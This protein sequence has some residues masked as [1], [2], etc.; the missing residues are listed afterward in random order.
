MT[1]FTIIILGALVVV[2]LAVTL[3][4][5]PEAA[6][7]GALVLGV[8]ILLAQFLI[9]RL[10]AILEYG[11][12][13]GT[14]A[15]EAAATQTP[16]AET[17]TPAETAPPTP[18]PHDQGQAPG[19]SIDW[20][21]VLLVTGVIAAAVIV[22]LLTAWT[23]TSVARARR[24]RRA[25]LA[26]WTSAS[27]AHDAVIAG[28]AKHVF[29]PHGTGAKT[30]LDDVTLAATATFF[31]AWEEADTLRASPR[32]KAAVVDEYDAATTRLQKAWR[33]AS[34]QVSPALAP[35]RGPGQRGGET[36]RNWW[37]RRGRKIP[38]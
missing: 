9:W 23:W 8:G 32:R 21:A 26:T 37:L 6:L 29:G 13:H 16:P 19:F 2:I 28:Y 35:P 22:L 3:G 15:E 31:T 27:L 7:M 4:Y 1:L 12:T 24:V 36:M 5:L 38:A 17:A 34:V 10:T 30:A 14:P 33:A 11:E 18:A 25:R 20:A